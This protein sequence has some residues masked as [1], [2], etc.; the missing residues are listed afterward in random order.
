MSLVNILFCDEGM[1]HARS[2]V[3]SIVVARQP[4]TLARMR[5]LR[6]ST[7]R[8]SAEIGEGRLG[9]VVLEATS[10]ADMPREVRQEG[11][12]LMMDSPSVS[13]AVVIEGGGFRA[14][15]GRAI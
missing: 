2:G 15:A 6:E 11:S 13:T 12:G 5:R 7:A 14:V 1:V 3:L 10:I 8:L 9:I 4:F